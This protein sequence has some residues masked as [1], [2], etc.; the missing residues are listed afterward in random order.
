MLVQQFAGYQAAQVFLGE[1]GGKAEGR[2]SG[3]AAGLVKLDAYHQAPPPHVFEQGVFFFQLIEP[4]LQVVTVYPRL[5]RQVLFVNYIQRRD[6]CC[7]R[8]GIAAECGGVQECFFHAP[9]KP[10]S[11]PRPW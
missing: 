9:R 5:L 2:F 7:G 1:P 4:R 6:G 3:Q 10:F 11:R 8:P